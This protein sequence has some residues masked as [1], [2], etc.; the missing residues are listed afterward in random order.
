MILSFFI[1]W[2]LFD[3]C[4]A[5]LAPNFIKYLGH[6]SHS[7][8]LQHYNLPTFIKS[9][10]NFDGIFYLRIAKTGYSQ[11]EQA[12]FPLYPL[13]I[14]TLSPIFAG[15]LLIAGLVLSNL[16]FLMGLIIFW[17]FLNLIGG[18]GGR[19][20]DSAYPDVTSGE[21][22]REGN[23]RQNL[24]SWTIIF[25]LTFPASF[26]FGAVYTE[27]LFFLL[28]ISSLH[29]FKKEKYWLA[30][31]TSLL[32][33][34]TRF[35]GVFLT[36]YFVV[37]IVSKWVF[38]WKSASKGKQR[39]G[40]IAAI[41]APILGLG[42]YSFYLFKTAG[43][44]LA[45]FHSQ[46]AFGAGRSTNLIFF[47]QVYYRYLKIF[48]SQPLNL[49]YWIAIFEAS[50]F[51]LFLLVLLYD[52]MKMWKKQNIERV[53][54]SL[55]SLTNLIVPTLTGTFLSIPRFALMSLSFFICMAQLKSVSVK[56]VV[57]LFFMILHIIVLGYFI[58]GYF[59]S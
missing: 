43:D 32:A 22:W 33:A 31:L 58:Q 1:V 17:K 27:G 36:L 15:N 34:S 20:P 19:A 44:P 8:T 50:V 10:A 6:F 45:F 13:L 18:A 53:G 55:F 46:S 38:W 49:Q 48:L 7:T 35:I 9:F 21:H 2:K 51:T 26:F 24:S 47:P 25:L 57:A 30:S 59:I 28:I 56:I 11:F 4:V 41:I 23:S 42:I 29:L 14:K 54:L 37:I 39:I 16:A 40:S 52:L 3:F 5:Y 12:F